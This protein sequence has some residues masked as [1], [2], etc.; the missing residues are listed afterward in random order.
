MNA[1]LDALRRDILAETRT[2]SLDALAE[3]LE[4]VSGDPQEIAWLIE[5]LE[6]DGCEVEAPPGQAAPD[7]R[8]VL[9]AARELRVR[10]GRAPT[11]E[12]IAHETQ[13]PVD[14]VRTALFFGRVMG[15]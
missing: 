5:A 15:R 3:R 13:L 6:A 9:P 2:I 7:L 4:R 12:E 10:L 14:A 11:P 8:R 1:R